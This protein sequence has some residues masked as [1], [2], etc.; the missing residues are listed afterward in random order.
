MYKAKRKLKNKKLLNT[1]FITTTEAYKTQN[2]VNA[3]TN[4][5]K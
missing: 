3:K 2:S 1:K 5:S 4:I